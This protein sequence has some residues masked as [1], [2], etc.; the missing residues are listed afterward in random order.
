VDVI[1]SES[2]LYIR[3][4]F[5]GIQFVDVFVFVF[6]EL[7]E[8]G[9]KICQRSIVQSVLDTRLYQLSHVLWHEFIQDGLYLSLI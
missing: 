6:V 8:M 9:L 4:Q 7:L 2:V 3:F 1:L 5:V